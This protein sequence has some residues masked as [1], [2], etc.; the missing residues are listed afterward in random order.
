[1]N[2]GSARTDFFIDIGNIRHNLA[3]FKKNAE[4]KKIMSVIKANAYGL[5]AVKIAG[6]LSDTVDYFGVATVDE[7]V[8]LRRAG[9]NLPILILGF[10]PCERYKDIIF[11]DLEAT[12]YSIESATALNEFGL[13]RKI[14]IHI[15]V[16]TGMNRLGFR[17]EETDKIKSVFNMENLKV[18][19][20]FTH[21][22]NVEDSIFTAWQKGNFDKVI[23][24]LKQSE[25][26]IGLTHAENSG[27]A[28]RA[29]GGY[30]M[31]RLGIGMYGAEVSE[32]RNDLKNPF[33]WVA[34][35]A[36]IKSVKKGE[37]I[38]YG[39]TFE[40][41]SDMKVAVVS[42]GYADGYPRILSN[43]GE[44][45]IKKNKANVVGRICMDYF[46]VNITDICDTNIC[47]E[48]VLFDDDVN[49]EALKEK[50]EIFPY[51]FLCNLGT[52]VNRIY[53]D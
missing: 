22:S 43:V 7:G 8:E 3:V 50:A 21:F 24:E 41:K 49:F 18:N 35:I 40:A 5:G 42:A 31:L 38:S 34:K 14:K 53:I 4:S 12:A 51:E 48:V 52:R 45:K 32:W 15:A 26:D 33:R 6:S 1:M 23:A 25:L 29:I 27:A 2:T 16:D 44:V 39:C 17:W 13:G 30:D 11:Y 36:Q 46:M 19:G 47:D 20:V 37:K 10:I 9:I 28:A